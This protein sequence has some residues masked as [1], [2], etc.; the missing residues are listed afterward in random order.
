M[1]AITEHIHVIRI[2]WFLYE[3]RRSLWGNYAG[4][5]L[6]QNGDERLFAAVPAHHVFRIHGATDRNKT[7]FFNGG[8]ERIMGAV[9]IN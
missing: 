2:T 8:I 6:W 5:L 7:V 9:G 4:R 3:N 1:L